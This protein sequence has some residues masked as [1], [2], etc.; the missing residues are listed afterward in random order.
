MTPNRAKKVY[1]VLKFSLSLCLSENFCFCSRA[2]SSYLI[3]IETI[4]Y[5]NA[6]NF[7]EKNVAWKIR[8]CI[9]SNCDNTFTVHR[10][11]FFLLRRLVD[12]FFS[13]VPVNVVYRRAF[14]FNRLTFFMPRINFVCFHWQTIYMG[15]SMLRVHGAFRCFTQIPRSLSQQCSM[16][17]RIAIKMERSIA[18]HT[19]LQMNIIFTSC[20]LSVS[21]APTWQADCDLENYL[22]PRPPAIP[23]SMCSR[24]IPIL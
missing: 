6:K 11:T 13:H 4:K 21:T 16:P 3:S 10:W 1:L 2:I 18:I 22:I 17:M 7:I 19:S 24:K 14:M 9:P 5:L 8:S 20:S 12:N 23:I 15:A